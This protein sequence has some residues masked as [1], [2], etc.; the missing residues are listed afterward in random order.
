MDPN[1]LILQKHVPAFNVNTKK[2][3]NIFRKRAIHTT[4]LQTFNKFLLCFFQVIIPESRTISL[5]GT[6]RLGWTSEADFGYISFQYVNEHD[7]IFRNVPQEPSN[8]NLDIFPETGQAY[9]FETISLPSQFSIGAII[10]TGE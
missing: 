5:D 1:L 8:A 9:D 3:A 2:L 7:T 10:Q 6:E 4:T